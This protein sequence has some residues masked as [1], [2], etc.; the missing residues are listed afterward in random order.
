MFDLPSFRPE[1]AFPSLTEDMVGC[2]RSYGTEEQYGSGAELWAC[3]QREIE[4]FVVLSGSINI[5]TV[6]K[7]GETET[8]AEAG[9]LQ[10]TGELNLLN[11]QPALVSGRTKTDSVVLR[12]SRQNL[13]KLMR[14][15]GEIANLIM[16]AFIWRRIGLMS[17]GRIGVILYGQEGEAETLRLQQFLTRNGYPHYLVQGKAPASADSI[18]SAQ[19][20]PAIALSDSRVLHRPTIAALA[21]ELG[22]TELPDASTVYDVA[23]VGAGPAGLAA[24]VYAA[25]EG[26]S[27]VAIEGIAPGGQ[28]GT[29]SKIE[30]YLGFPTGISGQRL[31]HRAWMQSLKFGVR[32][33]IAREAVGIEPGSGFHRLTLAEGIGLCARAVVIATGARYRKLQVEN[34]EKF[35]NQGIYYAATAMETPFC[36]EREVVVVGGGNSAGQAALFLSQI[37]SHVYLMIRGKSLTQTMSQYLL[38]R[39]EQS[40]RITVL[41]ETEIVR[42]A[43]ESRLE[44]VTWADR[45]SGTETSKRIDSVFVMIGAD[46]NTKWL[47]GL[48]KLDNKG[49]VK[50]GGSEAFENTSFATNVPGIYAVGDVRSE[51]VKRVASAVGQGSVV[52][53]DIHHYLAQQAGIP[54]SGTTGAWT[55]APVSGLRTQNAAAS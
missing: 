1:M 14:S 17:Q 44:N 39:I 53:S 23:V 6:N 19:D 36:H 35:E 22:I 16:Q 31:A 47:N 49:F 43:G 2:I 12:V 15:E 10:F 41:T 38:S 5:Y 26:L 28:A 32:F 27:T 18:T 7:S 51:S 33:A 37:A 46:P 45:R 11:D 25:S 42:L 3:N 48:V 55:G 8:V 21:D 30:N 20:L 52:I 29:S 40:P 13:R 24:A 34:L 50:T 54:D 4:M 9:P